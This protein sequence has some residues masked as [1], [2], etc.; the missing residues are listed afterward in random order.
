MYS[1]DDV[2]NPAVKYSS[3]EIRLR[4][5][6]VNIWNVKNCFVKKKTSF[7]TVMQT[8]LPYLLN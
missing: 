2:G 7:A 1:Q 5:G 8:W 4:V 3:L 6:K